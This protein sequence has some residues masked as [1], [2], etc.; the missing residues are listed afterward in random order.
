MCYFF[1]PAH[2]AIEFAAILAKLQ[3]LILLARA[4]GSS[5]FALWLTA[6]LL[7]ERSG[8]RIS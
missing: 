2:S 3:F 1:A 4:V 6:G 7:D 5:Y 8:G